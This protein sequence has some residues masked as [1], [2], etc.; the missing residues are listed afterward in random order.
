LN[1]FIPHTASDIGR[2]LEATGAR[3]TGDLFA[4]IP[5]GLRLRAKLDLPEG[6][7]EREV[8]AELS[9]LAQRNSLPASFQGAGSYRHFVP[10]VVQQITSR[11]EFATAYTPPRSSHASRTGVKL[12]S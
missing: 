12:A 1:R 4:S 9:A 2:M 6:L 10:T 5:A 3:S 8:I 11:S 7:S